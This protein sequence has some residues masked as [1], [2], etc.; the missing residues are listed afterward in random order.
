ME[1]SK[2]IGM[3]FLLFT[4]FALAINLVL[5]D[6]P[7][8]WLNV[9]E[10]TSMLILFAISIVAKQPFSGVIQIACLIVAS[11]L[12][13]PSP[14]GPFFSSAICIFALVLTYAYGGYNKFRNIKVLIS[15]AVMFI[16]MTFNLSH[17]IPPSF[18]LFVRSFSWTTFLTVFCFVLW[19]VV[20]EIDKKFH[21]QREQELLRLNREL[22]E[23]N[24]ELLN[25]GCNDATGKS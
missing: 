13:P 7:D 2:R 10:E 11:A 19:L 21:Y 24:H 18:E 4:S 23:L 25:G 9:L 22:I 20:E 14:G 12:S 8:F 15:I 16:I 3:V 17:L 5:P 1:L 6:N